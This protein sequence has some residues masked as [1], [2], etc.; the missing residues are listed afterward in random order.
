M[1]VVFTVD[2]SYM[3]HFLVAVHSLL[4]NNP[5]AT[6]YLVHNNDMSTAKGMINTY[7]SDRASRII[8]LSMSLVKEEQFPITHHISIATYFRIFLPE[9]LPS[10]ISDVLFLDADLIV[11]KP[12]STY[13]KII[14]ELKNNDVLI[15]AVSHGFSSSELDRAETIGVTSRSYFNAGVMFINIELMRKRNTTAMCLEVLREHRNKLLWH[16]QD[17]LNAVIN[18]SYYL[19]DKRYNCLSEYE[20]QVEDPIIVHYNGRIKP[21]HFM[22]SSMY[23]N[24]YYQRRNELSLPYSIPDDFTLRNIAHKYFPETV[25]RF[26]K[27][28]I[29]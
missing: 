4:L 9:I 11:R 16:D 8:P 20:S 21:W 17:L 29:S 26:V 22:N 28:I 25:K 24:E 13:S 18:G 10:E 1:N 27:K 12:I 19:L 6:V 7:I 23:K 3:E 14:D 15:A 5:D 2:R